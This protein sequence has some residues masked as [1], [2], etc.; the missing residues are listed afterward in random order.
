M[1]FHM[2]L[3]CCRLPVTCLF[4][5]LEIWEVKLYNRDFV[6]LA[7]FRGIENSCPTSI[8]PSVVL[9][10]SD[11]FQRWYNCFSLPMT[12]S[13]IANTVLLHDWNTW[14]SVIICS[15]WLA[16]IFLIAAVTSLSRYLRGKNF[17]AQSW[18]R[19]TFDSSSS[20]I[21]SSRAWFW[22]I[23]SVKDGISKQNC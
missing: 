13:M 6:Q 11:S 12:S 14:T 22:L 1:N 8:A 16:M 20:S 3:D 18:T 17:I 10:V 5:I 19:S 21:T 9:S 2:G 4:P 7:G 15:C 23:G